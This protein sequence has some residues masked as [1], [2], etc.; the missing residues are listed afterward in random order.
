MKKF[1]IT[2]IVLI[3]LA[4]IIVSALLTSS[5][6]NMYKKAINEISLDA[7]VNEIKKQDSYTKINEMPEM[8]KNAVVAVED[9]RFYKHKGVD[10]IAVV[11]AI[12]TNIGKR[13][14]VEGG[15]T[16]TQQLAKNTYFSQNK[17]LVRKIAEAFMA[18]QYEKSYSKD[19]ILELYANYSYFG[20]GYYD[21]KSASMGYFNKLPKDLNEFEATLLAGIPNAPSVYAPTVN[22][23][24]AIKRQKK[25]LD[26]MVKYG[27]I[28][29][30][31][32]N[33]IIGQSETYRKY[34]ED[35]KIIKKEGVQ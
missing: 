35:K 25:V 20:D 28:S 12:V 23:D 22:Y 2:L 4:I 27:Y 6:Y 7:K 31:K 19:D 24:L 32:K 21:I 33:E 5:G 3:L 34:F 30:I 13:E 18:K 1:F 17:Q 29:D 15:S 14:L 11:R 10:Y 9:H 26:D 16:I 8:Y